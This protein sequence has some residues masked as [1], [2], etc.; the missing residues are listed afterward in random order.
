MI[1]QEKAPYVAKSE[2][3]KVEYEKS[4]RAYNKKQVDVYLI[5]FFIIA[6]PSWWYDS[7]DVLFIVLMCFCFCWMLSVGRS[8][9][10]RWRRVWEV[11][12]W[13]EWWGWWWGGQCRGFYI[14]SF[15]TFLLL[16][17]VSICFVFTWCCFFVFVFPCRRKMMIRKWTDNHLCRFWW[18]WSSFVGGLVISW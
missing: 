1:V 12:I 8:Y 4:M 9:W 15:S 5:K 7:L 18:F 17:M 3:R 13:G 6:I 16:V 11:S 2:K 10:W 14:Y